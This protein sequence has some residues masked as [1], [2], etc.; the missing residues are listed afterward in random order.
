AGS[1]EAAGAHGSIALTAQSVDNTDGRIVNTGTGL[2]RI[3]ADSVTNAV[4]NAQTNAVTNAASVSQAAAST[5]DAATDAAK[6]VPN[7]AALDAAGFIGGNGAVHIAANVLENAT[8]ARLQSGGELV[9]AIARRLANG[10][11]LFAGHH[12]WLGKADARATAVTE[13]LSRAL[14]GDAPFAAASQLRVQ[15]S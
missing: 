12:L 15:N 3:V 13:V 9:L 7:D 4:T 1:I 6:H 8:S 11:T 5:A 2:T 10:G 14:A